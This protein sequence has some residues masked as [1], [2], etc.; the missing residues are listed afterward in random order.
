MTPNEYIEQALRTESQPYRFTATGDVTP[1]IEHA[2][3]GAVTEAAELM[4]AL[5]KSKIYGRPLDR[6]NLVEEM[7][8]LT[9]YLA[10]LADELGVSFEEIWEKNINKLRQRYP[11]KYSDQQ[12]E[13]RDVA[14]ERKILEGES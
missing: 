1:R 11:E 13:E 3:M 9:W 4:D 7:V 2:V 5:K 10:I 12:A 6:V 14:K 8:D